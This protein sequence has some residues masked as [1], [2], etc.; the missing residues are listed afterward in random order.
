MSRYLLQPST[1]P[2]D[3]P[4]LPRRLATPSTIEAEAALHLISFALLGVQRNHAPCSPNCGT[5]ICLPY[6]LYSSLNSG[7]VFLPCAT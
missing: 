5:I 3:I 7:Q 4:V 6:R 2:Q 1:K